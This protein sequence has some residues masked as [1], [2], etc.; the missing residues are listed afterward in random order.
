MKIPKA[1]KLP[2][3]NWH[4]VV[5]ID[6]QRISVT[7]S[8]KKEVEQKAAAIK[9]GAKIAARAKASMTVGDA[10]DRYIES[11]DTVL[12]PSTIN[13]YKK[14]RRS[15]FQSIINDPVATISQERIQRAVNTMA[16]SK[17]PKYVRN[18][19]GLFTAAMSEYCPDRV[20]R[21]TLPQKEAPKIRIPSMDDIR[22]LHEDCVG[23]PYELPFLL[24]VWLG[25]RTS[26]IRGLTWDCIDGDTLI[27]KQALVDGENGPE[28]KQPKTYSGN[29][30]LQIPPYIKRLLDE[31]PQKDEF[32]VH[33]TRNAMYN[34]LHRACDRNGIE[35]FRFHDLR[36]VNASVMLGLNVPDKYAMERMGHATN[37]ML[38][39]VYQHTMSDEAKR[40]AD[41]VDD[42]FEEKLH[43]KLHTKNINR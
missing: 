23:T 29:R 36:H 13:G 37:N 4:A 18:A 40:V 41:A 35:P 28:L 16:K 32:I 11:K 8:T 43:T 34:H 15:L 38:K 20:F 6:G 25:L 33:Y 1:I 24:A 7:A 2:S 3:G 19:Y 12:S 21:I 31:T 39:N 42:Y 26:E 27:I 30:R 9:S 5:M 10:I 14:L 22:V 17:S